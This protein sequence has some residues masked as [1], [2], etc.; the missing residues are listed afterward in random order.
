MLADVHPNIDIQPQVI[1]NPVP[2][3]ALGV[4]VIDDSP[5]VDSIPDL[6]TQPVTPTSIENPTE[7]IELAPVDNIL[8]PS[9]QDV[10]ADTLLLEHD[11]E[12]LAFKFT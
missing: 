7:T 5:I 11:D 9:P 1:Y 4:P 3:A 6:V 8:E 12:H 10:A 2:N